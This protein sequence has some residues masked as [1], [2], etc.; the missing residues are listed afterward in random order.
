MTDE[1]RADLRSEWMRRL[2]IVV[3]D[4]QVIDNGDEKDI[5]LRYA[6]AITLRIAREKPK[7]CADL[8]VFICDD[9]NRPTAVTLAEIPGGSKCPKCGA[10]MRPVN[11][12]AEL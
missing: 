9:C 6:L 3:D 5:R 10:E 1:Q 11:V 7:S 4:F 12:G 2:L 8:V